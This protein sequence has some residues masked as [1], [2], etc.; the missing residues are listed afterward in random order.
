METKHSLVL[1]HQSGLYLSHSPDE[2]PHT[3]QIARARRFMNAEQLQAFLQVS[4]Y[5]PEHPEEYEIV[6]I[7]IQYKEVI[8]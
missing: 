7:E 8:A 1:K 6:E 3:K 5:A 4:D 2:F